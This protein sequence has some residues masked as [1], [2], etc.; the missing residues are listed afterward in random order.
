MGRKKTLQYETR[1]GKAAGP[2]ARTSAAPKSAPAPPQ[3]RTWFDHQ[4]NV[5]V[6]EVVPPENANG[7]AE[8]GPTP[9]R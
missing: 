9:Q 3:L 2:A 4:R 7:S 8:Q 6:V 5:M 1:I